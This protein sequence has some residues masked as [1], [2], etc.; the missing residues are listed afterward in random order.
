MRVDFG[1]DVQAY[2]ERLK[3]TYIRLVAAS[4]FDLVNELLARHRPEKQQRWREVS[5]ADIEV[6]DN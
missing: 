6:L 4:N 1:M 2:L 3:A 5:S